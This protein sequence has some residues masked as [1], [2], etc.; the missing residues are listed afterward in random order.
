MLGRLHP[1]IRLLDMCTRQDSPSVN[2]VYDHSMR[3]YTGIASASCYMDRFFSGGE[4]ICITRTGRIWGFLQ[5]NDDDVHGS[6]GRS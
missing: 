1:W 4:A 3:G 5:G 2:T 6:S